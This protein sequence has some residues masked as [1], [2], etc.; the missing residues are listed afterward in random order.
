MED[1]HYEKVNIS[2]TRDCD[3]VGVVCYSGNGIVLWVVR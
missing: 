3:G 2:I 1:L